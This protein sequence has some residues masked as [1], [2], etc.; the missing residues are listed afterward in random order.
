MHKKLGILITALLLAAVPLYAELTVDSLA[1]NH[2]ATVGGDVTVTGDIAAAD[3][4][5]SGELTVS[6]SKIIVDQAEAAPVSGVAA[7]ATMVVTNAAAVTDAMTIVITGNSITSV[8]TVVDSVVTNM[9][10]EVDGTET[11]L[12]ANVRAVL[13]EDLPSAASLDVT[14]TGADVILTY[15]YTGVDGT[16]TTLSGTAEAGIFIPERLTGGVDVTPGTP[17]TFIWRANDVFFMKDSDTWRK[18]ESTT[19]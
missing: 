17:G 14:G 11:G 10:I 9:Q 4:T 15:A 2:D 7:A 6:G 12:A 19:P 3:A 1:V 16:N 8:F 5:F 18:I 13:L